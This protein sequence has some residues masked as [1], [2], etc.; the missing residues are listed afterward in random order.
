MHL[1]ANLSTCPVL[2]YIRFLRTCE[3][4]AT[5]EEVGCC[6]GDVEIHTSQQVV[7]LGKGRGAKEDEAD[8]VVSVQ[9]NP[10]QSFP[11]QR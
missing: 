6:K 11:L 5:C 4:R 9:G 8:V 1:Q 2:K 10:R 3:D 7:D